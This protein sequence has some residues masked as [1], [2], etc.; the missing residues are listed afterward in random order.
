MR[1]GVPKETAP[2]ERRVALV[3]ETVSRLAKSGNTVVVERGAGEASSFPD[4][5]YADA[6]AAI[7]DP[8][9]TELVVKGQKPSHD[10]LTRLREGTVLVAFPHPPPPHDP[11]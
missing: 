2:G 5:L 9:P 7:G 8:Y 6:G 4:R 3:P 11:V 1:I 10:E